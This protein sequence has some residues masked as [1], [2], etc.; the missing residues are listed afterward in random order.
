MSVLGSLSSAL[1]GDACLGERPER[2]LSST[3]IVL[4]APD[5]SRARL[6]LLTYATGWQAWAVDG[7]P[8]EVLSIQGFEATSV[9]ACP[10]PLGPQPSP[11]G[12]SAPSLASHRPLLAVAERGRSGGEGVSRA[13]SDEPG[14]PLVRLFSPTAGRA[15]HELPFRSDVFALRASPHVRVEA[16]PCPPLGI[17]RTGDDGAH[18]R[19]LRRRWSPGL[20]VSCGFSTPTFSSV[21]TAFAFEPA[22]AAQLTRVP[23]APS[24][25]HGADAP[26]GRNRAV[27]SAATG[28]ARAIARLARVRPLRAAWRALR[29]RRRRGR[30]W[31]R[32]R[33]GRGRR[34]VGGG[35]ASGPP[36][37]AARVEPRQRGRQPD[38]AGTQGRTRAAQGWGQLAASSLRIPLRS[39]QRALL[40]GQP[41][42][43]GRPRRRPCRR[44]VGVVPLAA[45]DTG[46]R[47]RAGCGGAARGRVRR[48]PDRLARRLPPGR[49]VP[50]AFFA[51]RCVIAVAAGARRCI[52][53]RAP[54]RRGGFAARTARVVRPAAAHR[55]RAR[56]HAARLPAVVGQRRRRQ[57][58]RQRR[59]SFVA[60]RARRFF[61]SFFF[62]PAAAACSIAR[63]DPPVPFT[64][65][66]VAIACH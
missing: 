1:A 40:R 23:H 13:N 43:P 9:A 24:V 27:V 30:R 62:R 5:G 15:V 38:G 31:R 11:R 29:R 54:Q 57:Q 7:V 37:T 59:R 21:R 46:R 35:G 20:G 8:C 33:V 58:Q 2:V 12:G 22:R 14:A 36:A 4:E 56:R 44:G 50:R 60:E 18:A 55:L 42:V 61:V 3:F 28:A 6:L 17:S 52:R 63:R 47:R 32:G 41:P 19:A 10:Q 66:V 45:G 16:P 48:H 53:R 49:P 64:P 34:R 65:R 26:A 51:H 39:A 25:V